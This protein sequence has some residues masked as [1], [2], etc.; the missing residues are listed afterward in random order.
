[1]SAGPA[2][3]VPGLGPSDVHGPA[4]DHDHAAAAGPGGAPTAAATGAAHHAHHHHGHA[5]GA[6]VSQGRAFALGIVL[7]ALFLAV[8]AYYGWTRGSLALLAD[9]GHNLGDV[10]GLVL[11]WGGLLAGRLRPD[12]RHTWGWQRASLLAAFGNAVLLLVAM[13]A[14]ALEAVQ[15]LSTP[16]PVPGATLMAV[17]GVGIIVNAATAMLFLRG[18]SHDLNIRGAFL[19]M[20]A[21]ALV[22]VGVVVAGGLAWWLGWTWIDPVVSLAIAALIVAGTWGLLRQSLHGLFDGVPDGVDL[23]AV[24]ACLASLPG[25]RGVHD[26]HVWSPGTDRIALTAHLLV[27]EPPGDAFYTDANRRLRQGFGIDHVTLQVGRTL[28]APGCH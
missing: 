7:N 20:V 5:H 3:R 14:L 12:D 27:D 22:S 2:G 1:M 17:A 8:E 16:A 11:A 25:V 21:D 19:H 9:A 24:R 6:P 23:P 13:G 10:A 15:R 18:R 28:A 26:L 4:H